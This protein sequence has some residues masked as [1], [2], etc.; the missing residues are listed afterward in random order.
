MMVENYQELV[1]QEMHFETF[2]EGALRSSGKK[3]CDV[4]NI[5]SN[6]LTTIYR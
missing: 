5:F 2:L 4:F 1:V 6:K 3:C